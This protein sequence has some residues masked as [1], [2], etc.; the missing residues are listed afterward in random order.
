MTALYG[1]F[2]ELKCYDRDLSDHDAYQRPLLSSDQVS[3]AED[4]MRHSH[5]V[6][7][8]QLKHRLA[9]ARE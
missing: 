4:A 2:A 6:L 1:V 3:E 8:T 7:L 9:L 5:L